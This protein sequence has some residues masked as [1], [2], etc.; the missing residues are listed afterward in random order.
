MKYAVISLTGEQR[1]YII[2]RAILTRQHQVFTGT[3]DDC[4]AWVAG[5]KRAIADLEAG[6]TTMTLTV[7][8]WDETREAS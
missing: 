3:L 8:P 7:V 2:K 1:G 4:R 5:Y 6:Q